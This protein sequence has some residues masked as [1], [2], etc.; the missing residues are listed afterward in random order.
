MCASSV[1][2]RCQ[3]FWCCPMAAVVRQ[4]RIGRSS[5]VRAR[6]AGTLPAVN[7]NFSMQHNTTLRGRQPT[8]RFDP[9]RSLTH[10]VKTISGPTSRFRCRQ[11]SASSALL[12]IWP[13]YRLRQTCD[14]LGALAR[15]LHRPTVLF[16][17]VLPLS[18]NSQEV[19]RS[20]SCC[21]QPMRASY[22][23][24]YSTLREA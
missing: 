12:Y 16:Q 13:A 19:K 1:P 3:A 4:R 2:P 7:T 9:Y 21:H 15:L 22:E 6:P 11:G 23:G 18:R 10:P 17:V 14:A 20:S 5:A 8:D 24:W